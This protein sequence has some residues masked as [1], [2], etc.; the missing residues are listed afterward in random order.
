MAS[1]MLCEGG[2]EQGV[3]GEVLLQY[4]GTA[5]STVFCAGCFEVFLWAAVEALP[6]FDDRVR[7]YMNTIMEAAAN[8]ASN[9]AKRR[10]KAGLSEVEPKE[11][12]TAP[13]AAESTATEQ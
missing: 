2:H 13:V 6:T 4:I 11:R 12:D 8:K 7:A 5:D 9:A 3:V 10:R 1:V